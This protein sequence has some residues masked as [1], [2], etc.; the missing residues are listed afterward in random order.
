MLADA[1]KR[2][3][4][5]VVLASTQK[6]KQ[7]DVAARHKVSKPNWAKRARVEKEER[8]HDA[9]KYA[10]SKELAAE[11]ESGVHL[12]P[13]AAGSVVISDLISIWH[14]EDV[15]EE[16]TARGMPHD[17]A[18]WDPMIKYLKEDEKGRTNAKSLPSDFKK[19]SA[20]VFENV[21]EEKRNWF[22][23]GKDVREGAVSFSKLRQ[24]HV[25]LVQ[26]ELRCRGI[27]FQPGDKV[28]QL[29]AVLKL[30]EKNTMGVQGLPSKFVSV[31]S[32]TEDEL[33]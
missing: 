4:E 26:E 30:D 25:L 33:G 24:K 2:H 17:P 5:N 1:V 10:G 7:A 18:K 13:R 21:P 28:K 29:V 6:R 32:L 3:R 9:A 19:V 23:S 27:P 31:C 20:A 14:R 22:K 11:V 12:P 8:K 16:L 15:S